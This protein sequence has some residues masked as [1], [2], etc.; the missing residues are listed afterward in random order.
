MTDP[1]TMRAKIKFGFDKDSPA[2]ALELAE[3]AVD[4]SYM[5]FQDPRAA[6]SDRLDNM[7]YDQGGKW[8]NG[9]VVCERDGCDV[10][11]KVDSLQDTYTTAGKCKLGDF[12]IKSLWENPE[13]AD[14][15]KVIMKIGPKRISSQSAGNACPHVNCSFSCGFSIDGGAGAVGNC[16]ND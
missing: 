2:C 11:V 8:Q 5:G 3:L 12:C 16:R 9:W 10:N 15:Y 13:H 6:A 1:E 14:S 4:T 7:G